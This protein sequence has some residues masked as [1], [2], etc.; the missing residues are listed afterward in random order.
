MIDNI[1]SKVNPRIVTKVTQSSWMSRKEN[2]TDKKES[3]EKAK[4]NKKACTK[5][6]LVNFVGVDSAIYVKA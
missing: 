4:Q 1:K 3:Y 2:F 5:H 6:T